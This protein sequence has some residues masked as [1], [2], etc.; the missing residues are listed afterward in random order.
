MNSIVEKIKNV[1]LDIEKEHEPL[2]VCGLFLR[3]D[4]IER[5]DMVVSATWLNS[6]DLKSY[7]IIGSKIQKALDKQE[8]I[9][10]SRIVIL[11]P[12]DPATI[13]LQNSFSI[14][15][16]KIEEVSSEVLSNRFGFTIKK[17]YLLRCRS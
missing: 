12:N 9:Q 6:S 16:G 1:V 10:F 4:P 11:D 2:L 7:E 3:S 17:G 14:T 15:N 13:F 8:L 5:W